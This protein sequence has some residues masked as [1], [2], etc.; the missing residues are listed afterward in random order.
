MGCVNLNTTK[1]P[2]H[3]F[4][5]VGGSTWYSLVFF[6]QGLVPILMVHYINGA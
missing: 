1:V 6:G 5:F 2:E 4:H 3:P